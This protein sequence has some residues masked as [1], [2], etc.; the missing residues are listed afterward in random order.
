MKGVIDVL[1]P[2]SPP[3][4]TGLPPFRF[5]VCGHELHTGRCEA[6]LPDRCSCLTGR[7]AAASRDEF[8]VW[9]VRSDTDRWLSAVRHAWANAVRR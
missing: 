4:K 6:R 9:A 7:E 3:V 1:D 5:C 8:D 2:P